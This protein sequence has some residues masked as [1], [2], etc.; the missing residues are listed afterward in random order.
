MQVGYEKIIF[1]Q[2]LAASRVVN[3]A[4]VRCYKHSGAGPWQVGD[5][6]RSLSMAG[7]GRLSVYDKKPQRCTED[8]RTAF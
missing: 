4:T 3:A 1:D 2:H 6:R 7:D 8:N 5:K